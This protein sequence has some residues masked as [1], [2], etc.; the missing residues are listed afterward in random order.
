M[1][2]NQK[3]TDM[4]LMYGLVDGIAVV[5]YRFIEKYI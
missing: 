1:Y 5:A 2:S 3:L 4:H